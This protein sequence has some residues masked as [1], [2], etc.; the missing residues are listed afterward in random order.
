MFNCSNITLEEN[1]ILAPETIGP[2]SSLEL[3]TP[4]HRVEEF[5][6]TFKFE[7]EVGLSKSQWK[8]L[9]FG[10]GEEALAKSEQVASGD[11]FKRK[12][13]MG[14]DEEEEESEYGES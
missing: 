10:E 11:A 2:P 8:A 6:S 7:S 14:E 9:K 3:S 1:S 13:A 12:Q 5:S 4:T